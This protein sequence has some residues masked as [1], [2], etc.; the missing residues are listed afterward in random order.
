MKPDIKILPAKPGTTCK[1]KACKRP[2]YVII[3]GKTICRECFET[4][5]VIWDTERAAA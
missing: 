2:G 1:A 5:V 3:G 4:M